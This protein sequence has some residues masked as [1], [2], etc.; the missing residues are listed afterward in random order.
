MIK[1]IVSIAAVCCLTVLV[2]A[3]GGGDSGG[4]PSSSPASP[5]PQS[6][7]PQNSASAAPAS[8]SSSAT[9]VAT[10]EVPPHDD[11]S[12]ANPQPATADAQGTD[13]NGQT[14]NYYGQAA[15]DT[16]RQDDPQAQWKTQRD[17][18]DG[19]SGNTPTG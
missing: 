16:P 12:D 4:S 18:G 10:E 3:C 2:S 14:E 13:T 7:A 15:P 8:G 5:S 9:P 6:P 11:Y 1:P 19:N 17:S